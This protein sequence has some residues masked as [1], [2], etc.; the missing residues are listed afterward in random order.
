MRMSQLFVQTL[1]EAPTEASLSGYQFLLRGGFIRPLTTGNYSF[2]PLGA[3][4][5]RK[6]ETMVRQSMDAIGGQEAT[7]PMIQPLTLWQESGRWDQLDTPPVH[8]RDRSQREVVMAFSHKEAVLSMACN[9]VQSYRQLP[10]LLYQIWRPFRDEGRTWG[11]LLGAQETL[12]VDGYSLHADQANLEK[13]SRLVQER[14]AGIFAGCGLAIVNVA[15]EMEEGGAVKARSMVWP[16]KAGREVLARCRDCGYAADQDIV[17]AGKTSPPPEP[18]RPMEDVET[19]ECKSIPNLARFLSIPEARTAKALFLVAYREG[20]GDDFIFVVVRGDT[21]LNE[22]KLKRVLKAKTVGPATEAEIRSVGAE[23]GYGSPVGLEGL[24]VVVDDLIPQS[25]NLVAGANRPGYHTLNV[26]YG[27]DYQA[28]IVADIT[29]V[30]DGDPC[31]ECGAALEVEQGVQMAAITEEGDGYSR[32]M[33]AT[34]LDQAGKTQPIVM[35]HYRLYAD[36]LLA[37][38]A[39]THHDA[40]GLVWP[41]PVAPYG[42]YLMTLGKYSEAADAVAERLYADLGAAGVDVLYDDRDERAGVKF[43]DADLLGIPLR[44]VIGER[45]LKTGQVELKRRHQAEVETIPTDGLVP[46]VKDFLNT[47]PGP[48]S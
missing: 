11:G 41:V 4:T 31:P 27:R 19:P 42:V 36:R 26:N 40:H 46:Y 25:P 20:Q 24:T 10:V 15:A 34:Y 6:I 30:R 22:A 13:F 44:V 48:V 12:V 2:L 28:A 3:Q 23:P 18:M 9:I 39:E 14:F 35:G 45:G 37:A 5:R 21:D 16:S 17:R 1:R 47:W 33:N 7:F 29:L 8:F 32:A 38:V 43:N